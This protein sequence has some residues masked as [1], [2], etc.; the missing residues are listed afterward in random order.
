M[1][2]DFDR[3]RKQHPEVRESWQA[4]YV[5]ALFAKSKAKA[6]TTAIVPLP[7][8]LAGDLEL[9]RQRLET[10]RNI[11]LLWEQGD[12]LADLETALASVP[13]TLAGDDAVLET[14]A[15][16]D[17]LRVRNGDLN[18]GVR[19]IDTY[20]RLAERRSGAAKARTLANIGVLR[21]ISGDAAGAL[22]TWEE[23]ITF[24]DVKGRDVIYL[25]AAIQG[26]GPAMLQSLETLSASKHSALVRLQALAWRAELATRKGTEPET[27]IEEYRGA[28]TRERQG[29]LRANLPLA[30]FGI[31]STGDFNANLGY[32]VEERL[33]ITL[34]VNADPWLVPPAPLTVPGAS[35]KSKTKATKAK[36]KAKTSKPAK[37]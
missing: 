30:G 3:V 21:S 37:P 27:A 22:A 31:L 18:A 33:T 9:Q 26:L 14:T 13:E 19:A 24:A 5:A 12:P 17:Y 11:V 23:A 7:E 8:S 32:S 36:A 35:K 4:T 16:L 1:A 6:W 2:S 28:V 20:T 10:L 15:L 25:N 34:S 29:E